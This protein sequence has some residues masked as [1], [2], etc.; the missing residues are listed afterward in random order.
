MRPNQ[1]RAVAE[2]RAL[3]RWGEGALELRGAVDDSDGIVKVPVRVSTGDLRR[4][5]GGLPVEAYE[6]L[7]I[8]IHKEVPFSPPWLLASDTRWT[9]HSHVTGRELCLYID[10]SSQWSPADGMYGFVHRIGEWLVAAAA[11]ELDPHGGPLHPPTAL[12]R[13]RSSAHL[14]VR[15]EIRESVHRRLLWANLEPHGGGRFDVTRF[16]HFG[17]DITPQ[18]A[19]AIIANRPLEGDY[20]STYGLLACQLEELGFNRHRL[21]KHI[22]EAARRNP[23]GAPFFVVVGTL[24]RRVDGCRFHHLVGWELPTD[25]ADRFRRLGG[26]EPEIE[27]LDT[28]DAANRWATDAPLAWTRI[29]EVRASITQRRDTHSAMSVFAGKRIE[30]WGC[31]ALGGWIAEFIVR[32]K[33]ASLTL[34]DR[35]SVNP[36]LVVRQP[37]GD[38]DITRSKARALAR[39]LRRVY[40][41][42]VLIESSAEDVVGPDGISPDLSDIDFLIDATAN[43]GVAAALERYATAEPNSAPMASVVTDTQCELTAM[44]ASPRGGAGP[45]YSAKIALNRLRRHTDGAR[46]VDAFWGSPGI[47]DLVQPEPGCSAPTFH[48]SAADAASAASTLANQ[49]ARYLANP[50]AHVAELTA[51]PHAESLGVRGG[52]RFEEPH[53]TRV[54]ADGDYTVLLT[55]AVRARIHD[56][57][58][59][60]FESEPVVETGGLLIGERND[61]TRTIIIEGASGPPSDSS[62]GPTGF[63]RGTRDIDQVLERLRHGASEQAAYLGDWHS[64]PRGGAALS[65]TD[66]RAAKGLLSDGASVLLIWAGAPD[67]P[68]WVAEVLHPDLAAARPREREPE[69]HRPVP[70]APPRSRSTQTAFAARKRCDAEMPPRRPLTP[71]RTGRAM[72]LVALS[73]G[74]F[75]AT[76]AGLGVLRFLADAD[77]L[78]DVRIISSVSGGSLANAIM[79]TQWEDGRTQPAFDELVLQPVLESITNRS[80]LADLVRN[81]WRAAKP[82]STR[83]TVL[84]DRLDKWFLDGRLLKDLPAG[85]WFMFNAANITEGVRFRFDADVI[86]DYV[87]GSIAT[88]D[89][90]MRVATAVAA[91]AAVPG[92]FPPLQLEHLEFPCGSDASVDVV[93]GG[94]YDNLGLE[95][96]QRARD[97][98]EDP[99]LI[100]LN[101]GAQL[102][103]GGR[104]GVINRIPV[105]GAF[106][107][108]N[109]VMYRQTSATRLRRLFQESKGLDGRPLA[110]F[111]LTTEFP[112]DLPQDK[113]ERLRAWRGRNEEHTCNERAALAALPT[114]FARIDPAD[115]LALVQRS[116]WL[117]GAIL[118]VHHPSLLLNSPTWAPLQS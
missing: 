84:A 74:G 97:E 49:I 95:A 85:T 101:A 91:S 3:A 111:N 68:S 58:S 57:A 94:V 83:T 15:G 17:P 39:R 105:V 19:A 23:F 41:S 21:A 116:W 78:D 4:Y 72:I 86:G 26:S 59:D 42:D 110:P 115:A 90:G 38:E 70:A 36:G 25:L 61:S 113:Q 50:D 31:G 75:R 34:R 37:Y 92:Y 77:L 118:S 51:L 102:T 79:A 47:D 7:E 55:E 8:W 60:A 30:L 117:A 67:A 40:G 107:R 103:R 6:D 93:D 5:P 43:R 106:R 63:V 76:L 71:A 104:T 1:A 65:P 12:S 62:L 54:R 52:H 66:R 27:D 82:G 56:I 13:E 33:P 80:L 9:Q 81:S 48:G 46:L 64:H 109:A 29:H 88:A 96:I 35:A 53:P 100:S 32:A 73:G 69:V 87:N 10:P 14:V 16:H 99:F 112:A 24:N 114:T 28:I 11:G 98:T 2:L 108:A 18:L 45:G 22:I 89:T 20:A 44:F